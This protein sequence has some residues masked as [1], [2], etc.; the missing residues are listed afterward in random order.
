MEEQSNRRRVMV[1][2]AHPDDPE[3]SCAGTVCRWAREGS[4]VVY[5]LATHGEAG[6]DDTSV[7]TE[8]LARV[9]EEEEREAARILGVNDVVFLDYP[10]G[11][12]VASLEL[13]RDLTQQIRRWRPDV[14]ITMDPN[15]RYR[16]SYL[17]HPDHRAV[18]GAVLDAVF[19]DARNPRQFPELLEE[20]LKP[21]RV[22]EVYIVC[23]AEAEAHIS[24]DITDTFEKKVAALSVHRSQI[25]DPVK[26]EE[27]LRERHGIENGNGTT[28]YVERFKH[29]VLR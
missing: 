1:I 29:I 11:S 22:Q 3:F 27:R 21:H 4:D 23:G 13:R 28:R 24:V 9:R 14:V 16:R 5:V 17:S 26:L 19:P 15:L 7:S 10:D 2:M 18:S 25:S 12:V 8:E 6:S 20:G